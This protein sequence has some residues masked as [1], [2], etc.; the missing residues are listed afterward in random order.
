[1][2][3]GF[4]RH[5]IRALVALILLSIVAPS[6]FAD[7]GW[8]LPECNSAEGDRADML[9]WFI[10]ALTGLTFVGTEGLLVYFIFKYRAKPG[11]KAYFSH[12]NH[13]VEVIW[14]L[15]PAVILAVL[16]FLQFGIWTDQKVP[17]KFLAKIEASGEPWL[18]VHVLAKQ[19]DWWFRYP[20][21][22][23]VWDT[24]DDFTYSRLVVPQN[25]PVV[26]RLRS[27]DVI[28]SLY[29]PQLRFKQDL[30]P[31]MTVTGWFKARKPGTWEIAC[32][33]LCGESHYKMRG[34]YEVV[35]EEQWDTRY[36]QLQEQ[37][38]EIDYLRPNEQFRFWPIEQR[39][40]ENE[41]ENK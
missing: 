37:Q 20:G 22:D 26:L 10:F 21:P 3:R 6:A 34:E 29:L 41:Q 19:F 5:G 14:T 24:A 36:R 40:D 11:Q 2:I 25:R 31:G 16:A 7:H 4:C 12:G 27:I 39:E 33:E 17:K 18:E 15:I 30:V 9:F 8:L 23:G 35:A 13:K 28:H 38:G 32:A 1:M